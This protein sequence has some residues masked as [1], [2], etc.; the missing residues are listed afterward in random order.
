MWK[1]LIAEKYFCGLDLGALTLKA[2]LIKDRP[3]QSP[4]LL[5]VCES[6]TMGFKKASVTDLGEL[7]ECVH[8]AVAGLLGRAGIR[9]KD[10]HL[11]IGGELIE[12]RYSAAVIPLL[13]RGSK[14]I[15]PHDI[16]KVQRQ[17]NLL[18]ANMDENVLHSFP[19]YY[20]VD[21]VN[22]ALNP[23]GL[24]GRKIEINALLL[25]VNNTLLRNI[26]KAVNHAGYDVSNIF[27]ASLSSA[28]ASLSEYHRRQGCVLIDAGSM[29]SDIL[30]FKDGQLKHV[31]NI[32]L[33]GEHVTSSI[34][35]RLGLNF[36]L[37][38]EIKKSYAFAIS[39]EIPNDEEILIKREDGYVPI[40]KEIIAQAIEPTISRFVDVIIE[41]IKN[42]GL[43]DEIRA[44]II[45]TGGGS[46]LPGLSERVEQATGIPV[47]VGKVG[48]AVKKLLNAPKYC[49]AAGLA[50]A[51]LNKSQG[52]ASLSS[53]GAGLS[54][55]FSARLVELYQEYF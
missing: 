16:K 29:M 43:Y 1:R 53:G 19:Q 36:D 25:L 45:M 27:Y 51:G 11:G 26:V 34:A 28:E 41:A 55:R 2:A 32:P 17:A 35:G 14:V 5:G 38:E 46:L 44:G 9:L 40:K 15:S 18:G 54:A 7:S 23:L 24:Y 42:S 37:A 31:V 20:K 33:G 48:I 52:L 30:I 12:K 39:A 6:R 3:N 50:Q 22:T 49:A 21:D 4:E 47:K 10:I 13:E 8:S